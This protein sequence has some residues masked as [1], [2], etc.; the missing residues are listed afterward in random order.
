MVSSPGIGALQVD[1]SGYERLLP[2]VGMEPMLNNVLG[3]KCVPIGYPGR[4]M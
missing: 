2:E 4:K 3:A 1:I